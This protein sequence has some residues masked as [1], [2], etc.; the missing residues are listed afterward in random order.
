VTKLISKTSKK[1]TENT[2]K[3]A[4]YRTSIPMKYASKFSTRRYR[5][6]NLT[7]SFCFRS[8]GGG[9]EIASPKVDICDEIKHPKTVTLDRHG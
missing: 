7:Y 3:E 6:K 5:Q 8:F 1:L 2:H 9:D 4:R